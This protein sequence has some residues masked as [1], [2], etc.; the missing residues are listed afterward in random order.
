MFEKGVEVLFKA[1]AGKPFSIYGKE[2]L[3]SNGKI[4]DEMMAVLGNLKF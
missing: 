1:F 4:H 2:I 3:A